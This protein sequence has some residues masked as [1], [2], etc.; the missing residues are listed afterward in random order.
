MRSIILVKLVGLENLSNAFG[1][2]LLFLGTFTI[3]GAPS[4]GKLFFLF[5]LILSQSSYYQA[6]F[7]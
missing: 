5:L 7:L 2:F 3:I 1:I 4:A 6:W